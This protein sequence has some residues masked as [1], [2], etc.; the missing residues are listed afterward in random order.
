MRLNEAQLR[1]FKQG[2]LENRGNWGKV[3]EIFFGIECFDTLK[4]VA[5][6]EYFD[7]PKSF[8]SLEYFAAPKS[9]DSK[10]PGNCQQ[11]TEICNN[12]ERLPLA[13]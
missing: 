12:W 6:L 3:D 8:D 7:A 2:S 10:H 11:V 13:A 4:S 9:F 5:P 1:N